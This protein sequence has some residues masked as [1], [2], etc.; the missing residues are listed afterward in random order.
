MI[1]IPSQ[2]KLYWSPEPYQVD[3]TVVDV[4][5]GSDSVCVYQTAGTLSGQS[6]FIYDNSVITLGDPRSATT[7]TAN[8][9]IQNKIFMGTNAVEFKTWPLSVAYEDNDW[10][11]VINTGP[12]T[13]TIGDYT[14]NY[15]WVPD[16]KYQLK[17][18]IRQQLDS[19][20]VSNHK[21]KLA[22]SNK[23][24][25]NFDGISQNEIRALQL[26]KKVVSADDFRKYLKYGIVTVKGSSGLIYEIRRR[27]NHIFVHNLDRCVAELCVYLGNR[28]I[29]STDEVI[30]KL[31]VIDCDEQD[32]WKRSNIYWR[33]VPSE[34][35]V[36]KDQ[37]DSTILK[38]IAA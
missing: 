9:H 12:A 38:Q 8:F 15:V 17:E 7:G 34:L 28:N 22:R 19:A 37:F 24:A 21:G 10:W 6:E 32:I 18:K 36:K 4:S 14:V 3:N 25:A 23:S 16:K 31:V 20:D 33:N 30:T 26:L 35:K 27:E 11:P 29:P 5:T 13:I 2:K 1:S